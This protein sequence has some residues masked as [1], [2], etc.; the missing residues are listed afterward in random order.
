M[1]LLN[2]EPN[3]RITIADIRKHK[4]FLSTTRYIPSH[5]ENCSGSVLDPTEEDIADAVQEF[6]T[7]IHILVSG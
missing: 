7:P 3:D 1:R 2:K 6:Q 4:W 5:N